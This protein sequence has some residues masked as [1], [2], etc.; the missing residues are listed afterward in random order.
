MLGYFLLW[1]YW[2]YWI[3]FL[4]SVVVDFL[5][6]VDE[7]GL[8]VDYLHAVD[9]AGAERPLLFV[10]VGELVH[11]GVGHGEDVALPVAAEAER[12]DVLLCG[13]NGLRELLGDVRLLGETEERLEELLLVGP[14]LRE[15]GV[16]LRLL[17]LLRLFC[18]LFHF[19]YISLCVL[20]SLSLSLSL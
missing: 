2:I 10:L 8:P 17:L 12:R 16:F 11:L 15:D 13:G 14:L 4:H 18:W 7:K 9:V 5:E 20:S 19:I 1:I 6:E 3:I